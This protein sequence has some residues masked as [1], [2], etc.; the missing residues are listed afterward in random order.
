M[1]NWKS[2]IIL[3]IIQFIILPA[4][5]FIGDYLVYGRL[6]HPRDTIIFV[7]ICGFIAFFLTV[8]NL[9]L[10][11]ISF[12]LGFIVGTIRMNQIFWGF[13]ITHKA[14]M[15]GGFTFMGWIIVGFAMGAALQLSVLASNKV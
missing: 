3:G 6:T 15:S 5:F 4:V 12:S 14:N 10:W 1:R 13:T 9:K 8:F 2:R 11:A 7:Y